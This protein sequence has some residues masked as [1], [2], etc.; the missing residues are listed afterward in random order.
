MPISAA[1]TKY[2]PRIRQKISLVLKATRQHAL[3]LATFAFLYKSTCLTLRSLQGGKER[4]AD[5]FLAGALGGWYVFG[6][7]K[8]SVN[9]QIVIYVAARVALAAATLAFRARSD[10]TLLGSQYGGR[11]GRD[12]LN[13]SD[14]T[15]QTIRRAAWPTFAGLSWAAVMWLFKHHPDVLQPSLKSS[16]VYMYVSGNQLVL[17]TY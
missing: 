15:R 9:Q 8:S 11:G 16:M 14:K 4:T 12:L 7:R 5:S 1:L 6:R 17:V 13:L 2:I 3:N 10:N